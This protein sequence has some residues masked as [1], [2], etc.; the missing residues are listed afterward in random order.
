M[1]RFGRAGGG[2]ND[3]ESVQQRVVNSGI[4]GDNRLYSSMTGSEYEKLVQ[5][6]AD[7]VS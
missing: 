5:A 6:D 7:S 4:Q 2:G 3:V 1:E